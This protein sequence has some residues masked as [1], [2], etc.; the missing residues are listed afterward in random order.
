MQSWSK[1]KE[2][3]ERIAAGLQACPEPAAS[4]F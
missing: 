2:K 1:Q 3:L 4:I